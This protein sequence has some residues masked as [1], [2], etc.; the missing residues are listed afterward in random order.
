MFWI[1]VCMVFILP[2]SATKIYI[3]RKRIETAIRANLLLEVLKGFRNEYPCD[4]DLEVW[5]K[6]KGKDIIT[7]AAFSWRAGSIIAFFMSSGKVRVTAWEFNKN[8]LARSEDCDRELTEFLTLLMQRDEN[9][10]PTKT[11]VVEN[12]DSNSGAI[13][14]PTNPCSEGPL[15]SRSSVSKAGH[16]LTET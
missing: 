4:R 12:H 9:S 1:G 10:I 11:V 15:I 13:V 5:A 3:R 6:T 7:H 16:P 14:R 8:F 2:A